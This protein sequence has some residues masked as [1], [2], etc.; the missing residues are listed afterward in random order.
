MCMP[1]PSGLELLDSLA[2][3]ADSPP[4][5]FVTAYSDVPATVHAMK[6][7]ATDFLTKPIDSERLMRA[8]R[9][10]L[11]L[12]ANRRAA[13][14]E[15]QELQERYVQLTDCE[16]DVFVGVVNGKLNKQ[17]AV[18]LGI[19]ERSIKSYRSRVMR[20]MHVSSLAALVRTAKLLDVPAHETRISARL[21]LQRSYDSQ[22][23]P[24]SV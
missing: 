5:I 7:G 16:R 8:I 15:M 24:A 12:D 13:R 9:A 23:R 11:S 14:S 18:T 19:C 22:R 20:K 17:L 21:Q 4:V 1:G 6:A 2:T 3:Q 10:A